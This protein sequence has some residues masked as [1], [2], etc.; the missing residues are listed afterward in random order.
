MRKQLN[1][2]FV[3]ISRKYKELP[4]EYVDS[5]N[6]FHLELPYY[7]SLYG[8]NKVTITTVDGF[9]NELK[10]ARNGSGTTLQCIPEQEYLESNSDTDLVCHWR[11]WN[12]HLYNRNCLNIL[13]CQDHTFDQSWKKSV[14]LAF[15]QRKLYGILCFEGGW[16]QQHIY[17]QL[18]GKIP[19]ERLIED[20]TLGVDTQIFCPNWK[21]KNPYDMLWAG[22]PGRGLNKTIEIAVKLFNKDK[23]FKLHICYPDYVKEINKI[24]H[25]AL[26]WHGNIPASPKLFDLFNTC[27]I[28]PYASN[29]MEPSSRCHRQS[30]AAGSL[31]LYPESMGSP[32]NLIRNGDTGIVANPD[33]WVDTIYKLVNS[34]EWMLYGYAAREFAI[35]ENWEV[36][37]KKFNAYFDRLVNGE[38]LND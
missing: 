31:V 36:K 23:R 12:E 37:S 4:A 32:S 2:V 15:E 18:S 7:Y 21:N 19:K 11:K 33:T 30:Q 10:T 1:I 27:G 28:L 25:P 26:I 17:E 20:L 35:S 3:G 29:F 8:G 16:H 9:K 14:I 22:D 34:G 6:K 24:N 5:F 38:D 13:N